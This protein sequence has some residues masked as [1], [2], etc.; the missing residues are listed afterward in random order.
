MST[1]AKD[2]RPKKPRKKKKEK[3]PEVVSD[4]PQIAF[5]KVAGIETS[6]PM[7]DEMGYPVFK[8]NPV[9]VDEFR[10]KELRGTASYLNRTGYINE[11]C[12][13]PGHPKVQAL[14]KAIASLKNIFTIPKADPTSTG[15]VWPV[16]EET[17]GKWFSAPIQLE[18]GYTKALVENF[19]KKLMDYFTRPAPVKAPPA[20]K[21]HYQH[22]LLSLTEKERVKVTTAVNFVRGK[23][24]RALVQ[25]NMVLQ[26][27]ENFLITELV[28]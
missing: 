15:S 9:C 14:P 18:P 24:L 13:G 19:Q 5:K 2:L 20:P 6:Q 11:V 4:K 8:A 1:P 26:K 7:Q 12:V 25:T 3:A 17:K 10:T 22:F 27:I 28:E 23:V 16:F 21:S